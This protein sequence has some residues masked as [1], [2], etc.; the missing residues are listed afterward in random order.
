MPEAVVAEQPDT[1][2]AEAEQGCAVAMYEGRRCG[3]PIYA[4]PSGVDKEP[5]CL[6]HSPDPDKD[7]QAFQEE[8]ERILREAGEGVAD[9]SKFVFPTANYRSREF[10][11]ACIF[12][13]AKFTRDAYFSGARFAQDADFRF[14]MFTRDADFSEVTFTQDAN[15]TRAAFTRG[16]S[17]VWATFGQD[18]YF[19]RATFTQRADFRRATFERN[20]EFRETRFRE[21]AS[22]EPGPV[23]VEAHFERPELVTFYMTYLGQASSTIAIFRNAFSRSCAGASAPTAKGWCWKMLKT[24]T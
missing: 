22:P 3:R 15:F 23:F 12:S 11:V 18:V 9:F 6:M 7:N 13:G 1:Q 24:S 16:A 2:V 8:F 17:F 4:A 20:A 21:D 19:A 14:A 5:V 10:N